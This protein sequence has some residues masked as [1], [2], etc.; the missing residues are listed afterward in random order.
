MDSGLAAPLRYAPPRND[1]I[2]L[3][4]RIGNR[5]VIPMRAG[6]IPCRRV[7]AVHNSAHVACPTFATQKRFLL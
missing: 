4:S 3:L 7:K 2:V 5:R 1:D 6:V